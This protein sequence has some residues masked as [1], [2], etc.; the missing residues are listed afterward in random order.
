MQ[1]Q[2]HGKPAGR[3]TTTY[4]ICDGLR[5]LQAIHDVSL[6]CIYRDVQSYEPL[7]R[8]DGTENPEIYWFHNA[9]NGMPERLTDSKGRIRWEGISTP[10]GKL[11][12]ES[13][14]RV[15]GYDQNLRLQGQYLD[16]ETGLHYNLFRYDDPDS[17]RFTQ[18]DPIG[19]AGGQNEY[20]YAP[21]P[22]G[23]LDPLG[24]KCAFVQKDRITQ[25]W[26]DTLTGKRPSDVDSL[27]TSKG[28]SKKYPQAN[29]PGAIQHTQYV[30]P[31]KSGATYKL[32]YHPGDSTSQQNIHENDY[33]K[34]YREVNDKDVVYGRIGHGE[35]KNYDLIT[36]PPVYV[37]RVLVN[38][39]M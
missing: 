10:W 19:L 22:L 17:A 33:C 35:F 4:F 30:K 8:V 29:K 23:W 1:R 24:L 3:T 6:T 5:L 13:N 12:S 18:Q 36:D 2:V 38:G 34:F 27:L 16:R 28:W 39:G 25:R 7:A 37:D 32:D 14:Q 9:A 20:A 26:T 11:L 31:K 21:N 15:Q